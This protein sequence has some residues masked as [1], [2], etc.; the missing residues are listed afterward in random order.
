MYPIS[1][2]SDKST[3]LVEHENKNH[4]HITIMRPL[5]IAGTWEIAP[6]VTGKHY[7][8]LHMSVSPVK[9]DLYG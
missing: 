2:R 9:S 1:R 5:G 4:D 3:N 6:Q 7:L 8:Y